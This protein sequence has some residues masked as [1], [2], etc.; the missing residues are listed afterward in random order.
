DDADEFDRLLERLN[1]RRACRVGV[2]IKRFIHNCRNNDKR[3]GPITTEEVIRER[4]WWI[5]RVQQRVQKEPHYPKLVEELGLRTNADNILAS[6]L[7]CSPCF[8]HSGDVT[9]YSL[10]NF[11]YLVGVYNK[12][13]GTMDVY[14]TTTFKLQPQ[15]S[16]DETD[17]QETPSSSNLSFMEKND[18]LVDAFGSTRRKKAMKSRLQNAIDSE[19]LGHSVSGAVNHMMSQPERNG[20][21]ASSNVA[22]SD[23]FPRYN[24]DGQT[25]AEIY[26]LSSLLSQEDF[27]ALK[28]PAIEMISQLKT[29]KETWRREN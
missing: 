29:Y 7:A 11:R 26:P 2:W 12:K 8:L 14:D 4:D 9:E 17:A 22:D 3:S 6:A 13:T 27:D 20:E 16:S 23:M 21:E 24:K 18:R 15:I 19:E 25:A 5:R 28:S 1:L 10:S